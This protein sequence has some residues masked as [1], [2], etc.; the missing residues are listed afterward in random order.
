MFGVQRLSII[1][2]GDSSQINLWE[3]YNAEGRIV[4]SAPPSITWSN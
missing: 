3:A 4:L 1:D 2:I